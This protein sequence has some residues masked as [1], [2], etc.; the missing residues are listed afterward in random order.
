MIS[1]CLSMPVKSF[2]STWTC[3]TTRCVLQASW[4]IL[5][6]DRAIDSLDSG[7]PHGSV[8]AGSSEQVVPGHDVSTAMFVSL[9]RNICRM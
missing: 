3:C 6:R 8:F 2:G 7:R 4:L 9:L 5:S 1:I